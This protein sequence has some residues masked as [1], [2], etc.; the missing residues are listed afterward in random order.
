LITRIKSLL[1]INTGE[2][3]FHTF[4]HSSLPAQRVQYHR[5]KAP[6]GGSPART[7]QGSRSFATFVEGI[8][9]QIA[10]KERA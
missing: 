6:L 9:K 3:S 2:V 5:A 10:I 7:A 1:T 4:G 8:K